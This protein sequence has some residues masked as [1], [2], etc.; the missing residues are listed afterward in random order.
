MGRVKL[1]GI[2]SLRAQGSREGVP[3]WGYFKNS[4]ERRLAGQTVF[5]FSLNGNELAECFQRYPWFSYKMILICSDSLILD[6]DPVLPR[7]GRS[8]PSLSNSGSRPN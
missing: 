3:I 1:S 2:P 4:D 7:N 5:R 8:S 6:K